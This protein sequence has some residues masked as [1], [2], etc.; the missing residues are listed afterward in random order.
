M[1][2]EFKGNNTIYFDVYKTTTGLYVEKEL[3]NIF[4]IGSEEK[5]VKNT[6]CL[7][8]NEKEIEE[9]ENKMINNSIYKPNY[10]TIF[11]LQLVLTYNV[12]VDKNH[13]NKL[14]ITDTLCDK[15][16]ITPIS[17]RIINKVTYS[18]IT[19][20]DLDNIEK[21]SEKEK[22]LLKR[23]YIEIKLEDKIKPAEQLFM[24]YLNIDDKKM[25]INR[26][27]LEKARKKSI[28]IE[29]NPK[30][31]E[32]KNCYSITE[33]ELK[34]L[35]EKTSTRGIERLVSANNKK[36]NFI[37]KNNKC[38][39]I[40]IYKDV[41][42]DKLYIKKEDLFTNRYSNEKYILNNLCNEI[43][44]RELENTYNRKFIIVDIYTY[45]KLIEYNIIVCNTNDKQFISKNTLLNF[46][47]YLGDTKKII[48]NKEIYVQVDN[49]IINY[50]KSLNSETLKINIINK[51]IIPINKEQ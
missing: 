21:T 5:L 28:E 30:V 29:A 18:H 26:A 6:L 25:Y 3:C 38:K 45:N 27:T 11:D 22:L 34:E 16:N 35:E 2:E 36:N 43:S 9:I 19:E 50:I 10:V 46:N 4:N 33:K 24:Y 14:Y 37:E 31:I 39:T 32:D 12:Y 44:V 48:I 7:K 8:V 23:K 41:I 20:K 1:K 42:A 51:K 13:E 40:I 49:N 17:K 47:I 15:Y